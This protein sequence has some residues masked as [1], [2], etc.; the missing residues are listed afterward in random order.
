MNNKVFGSLCLDGRQVE[1]DLPYEPG[2]V[3]SIEKR[4]GRQRLK[5]VAVNGLLIYRGILLPRASWDDLDAQGLITGK[6][7]CFDGVDVIARA[8]RIGSSRGEPCEWKDL[9]ETVER[10]WGRDASSYTMDI[11]QFWGQEDVC[12]MPGHK[13]TSWTQ[14]RFAYQ[15]RPSDTRLWN[16][17]W[18]PI[19]EPL[20]TPPNDTLI[21]RRVT[22][23]SGDLSMTGTQKDFSDYD[24]V[25]ELVSE[26]PAKEP[27]PQFFSPIWNESRT[28]H[29]FLVDR[30]ALTLIHPTYEHGWSK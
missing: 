15:A 28:G 12:G 6:P 21:G 11:A 1:E 19:L 8:P 2:A 23:W 5:W 22:V 25:L 7:M 29:D 24:L 30:S 27:G 10:V 14:N 17:G 16:C 3:I 9:M 26:L 18:L 20:H 4:P 13:A